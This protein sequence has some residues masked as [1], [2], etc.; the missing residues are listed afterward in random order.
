MSSNLE[1]IVNIGRPSVV[2]C[3]AVLVLTVGICH[4]DASEAVAQTSSESRVRDAEL[5]SSVRSLPYPEATRIVVRLGVDSLADALQGADRYVAAVRKG[6]TEL[7]PEGAKTGSS[8]SEETAVHFAAHSLLRGKLWS[9]SKPPMGRGR[10]VEIDG[11][12]AAGKRAYG[13]YRQTDGGS[14]DETFTKVDPDRSI[15]VAVSTRHNG[16]VLDL[17]RLTAPPLGA[18]DLP[19][20]FS[21]R[22]FFPAKEGEASNL[23]GQMEDYCGEDRQRCEH[24][25][26][27]AT[28]DDWAVI[29]VDSGPAR[30]ASG[31]DEMVSRPSSWDGTD[32]GVF[33]GKTPA[34][35]KFLR[36]DEAIT[37][38]WRVGGFGEVGVL[39]SA[40]ETLDAI[41]DS[42][43]DVRSELLLTGYALAS[44]VSA[45]EHGGAGE[46]GDVA[47]ELGV[48]APGE[49][50]V[51]SVLS[52]TEEGR[53]IAADST[54]DVALPEIEKKDATI[55]FEYA[56]NLDGALE[57]ATHPAPFEEALDSGDWGSLAETV[58]V[59]GRWIWASA[60]SRFPV[61][62]IKV[63][64]SLLEQTPGLVSNLGGLRKNPLEA[65]LVS[66][67]ETERPW[68]TIRALRIAIELRRDSDARSGVAP[69]GGVSFA[70]TPDSK[71]PELVE[72]A[73][74]AMSR[75]LG[76]DV[77]VS[78]QS[79]EA[80][81]G[82]IVN[83][84]FGDHVQSFGALTPVEPGIGG[85]AE[86]P[87][88]DA[89]NALW[90]LLR[91]AEE[92]RLETAGTEKGAALRFHIGST[93]L[94]ELSVPS[95][96]IA[97]Q[98]SGTS[99]T[100]LRRASEISR[101]GLSVLGEEPEKSA[102][103]VS[104]TLRR[105]RS[106]SESCGDD[107]PE[108]VEPLHQLRRRWLYRR[109][110]LEVRTG[111]LRAASK[112]VASACELSG[113]S[114]CPDPGLWNL[115]QS[116]FHKPK[117]RRHHV[118][119]NPVPGMF[120][121]GRGG[122]FYPYFSGLR[123]SAR[124]GLD[125]DAEFLVDLL[126]EEKS[127]I[128]GELVP[129]LPLETL[130]LEEQSAEDRTASVGVVPVDQ[131]VGTG[132]LGALLQ[133]AADRTVSEDARQ[134]APLLGLP[135]PPKDVTGLALPVRARGSNDTESKS[136]LSIVVLRT[137][138]AP[139]PEGAKKVRLI[140]GEDGV[141]VRGPD[142][143]SLAG[144]KDCRGEKRTLCVRELKR[145]RE[146]REK[147][148]KDSLERGREREVAAAL[149]RQFRLAGLP[150]LLEGIEGGDTPP[151]FELYV[152]SDLPVAI[153][154]AVAGEI[155]AYTVDLYDEPIPLIRFHE[156]SP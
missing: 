72:G 9:E 85:A 37:A 41:R 92:F 144:P 143:N 109:A 120:F 54:A 153:V 117:S 66:I 5:D 67:L 33:A 114:D 126:R 43:S 138:S 141:T 130:V 142:G 110:I 102:E 77:E 31:R 140:L 103:V 119:E 56:L 53:A 22:L 55:D 145:A 69:D 48:P 129:R 115:D 80:R 16:S 45:F 25:V 23:I 2:E 87:E 95:G 156:G 51:T 60:L 134:R 101:S 30:N 42:P 107:R 147:F 100:C 93:E 59:G 18:R 39:R 7:P 75:Y 97:S 106:D 139:V 28:H 11:P 10:E 135:K 8:V 104:R 105:L 86:V 124:F 13:A 38:Y 63:V 50:T 3:V 27:T 118:L 113:G 123:H 15:V 21:F 131:T 133:V 132:V 6:E 146:L 61:G 32:S 57:Q 99:P 154:A 46:F 14:E 40:L 62:L 12:V 4:V 150:D 58:R 155:G 34:V 82:T 151:V 70:V 24:V 52:R 91:L 20:G 17:L 78:E 71:L 36:S 49:W 1:D 68:R 89:R 128:R 74:E 73:S 88:I 122:L 81:E 76:V 35:H 44:K 47:L 98:S 19:V 108:T 84:A 116:D 148:R 136:G 111:R 149:V 26:R 79:P 29:E 64:D 94:D 121:V 152:E 137:P 125:V 96:S 112:T 127:T 83:V 65:S 90:K